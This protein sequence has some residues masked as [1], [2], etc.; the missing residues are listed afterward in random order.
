MKIIIIM[1]IMT[2]SFLFAQK[3][4]EKIVYKKRQKI[5]L[6]AL[7]IDGKIV[8]PGDFSVTDDKEGMSKGLFKRKH[9]HDRISINIEHIL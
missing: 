7:S 3:T 1:S 6:G 8:S 2:S 9:Y 5:D 4:N